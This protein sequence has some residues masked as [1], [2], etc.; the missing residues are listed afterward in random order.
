[1]NPSP[2]ATKIFMVLEALEFY[3]QQMKFPIQVVTTGFIN[4]H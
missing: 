3:S 4:F 2:L 1:M